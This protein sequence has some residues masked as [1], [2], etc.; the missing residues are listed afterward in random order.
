[1]DLKER[2]WEDLCWIYQAQNCEKRRT[3]MSAVMNL[4]GF[5]KRGE[6]LAWLGK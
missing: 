1:M 6:F 5:I 4:P 3:V 2:G